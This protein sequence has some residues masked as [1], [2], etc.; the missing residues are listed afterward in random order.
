MSEKRPFLLSI[1]G[2]SRRLLSAVIVVAIIV[3]WSRFNPYCFCAG[4]FVLALGVAV[5]FYSKGCL[6]RNEVITTF[7]PYRW[8]RHP[9]Y[10]GNFLVDAGLCVIAA[11]PFIALGYFILFMVGYTATMRF[12]ENLLTGLHGEAYTEYAKRVPRLL[13][14]RPPAKAT[15]EGEFSW[16]KIIKEHELARTMRLVAYPLLFRVLFEIYEYGWAAFEKDCALNCLLLSVFL[17]L[18][19]IARFQNAAATKLDKV[20]LEAWARVGRV[21][22]WAA[23]PAVAAGVFFINRPAVSGRTLWLTVGAVI[24]SLGVLIRIVGELVVKKDGQRPGWGRIVFN[25]IYFGDTLAV[26]GLVVLGGAYWLS[27]VL[28]SLLITTHGFMVLYEE[29]SGAL[30]RPF[31]AALRISAAVVF[32]AAASALLVFKP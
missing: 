10:L 30:K 11:N 29:K 25:P 19:V 14:V 28:F 18:Q 27:A 12:E 16:T 3:G 13:P 8:V 6:T 21:V 4:T 9:F 26:C 15:G 22:R 20:N 24:V 17:A 5:H 32:Y 7:G 1:R 23:P 2:V 31:P